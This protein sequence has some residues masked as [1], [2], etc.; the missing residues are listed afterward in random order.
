[1][2][3]PINMKNGLSVYV[4]RFV[5]ALSTRSIRSTK[6]SYSDCCCL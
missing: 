5:S 6:L 1:M 4:Y 3:K 2:H